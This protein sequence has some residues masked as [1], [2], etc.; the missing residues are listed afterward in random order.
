[1]YKKQS[2]IINKLVHALNFYE[3]LPKKAIIKINF[4]FKSNIIIII[5]IRL[6]NYSFLIDKVNIFICTLLAMFT[7]NKISDDKKNQNFP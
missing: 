4:T 1:M 7:L 5:I 6:R 2:I 3:I